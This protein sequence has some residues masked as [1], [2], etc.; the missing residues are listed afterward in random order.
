M[1]VANAARVMEFTSARKAAALLAVMTQAAPVLDRM[2]AP[3][4]AKALGHLTADQVHPRHTL[5]VHSRQLH[6]LYT[7]LLLA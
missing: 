1:K 2:E 5:V 4:A 6:P 7:P 3:L